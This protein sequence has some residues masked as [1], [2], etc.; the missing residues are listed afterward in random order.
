M[1]ILTVK[2]L[3]AIPQPP[4]CLPLAS[5]DS[6]PRAVRSYSDSLA[7]V[8]AQAASCNHAAEGRTSRLAG[9]TFNTKELRS[10]S[11]RTDTELYDDSEKETTE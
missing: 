7:C 4:L 3:G 9:K 2:Q 5:C 6:P 11:R 1:S 8:A 10:L